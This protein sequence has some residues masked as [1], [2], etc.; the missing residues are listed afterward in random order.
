MAKTLRKVLRTPGWKPTAAK[1]PG[2]VPWQAV[3]PPPGTY[4]PTIDA[5]RDAASRGLFDL[6]Q[7]TER[8]NT[9]AGGDLGLATEGVNQSRG[10]SLADNMRTRT[11]SQEDHGTATENLGRQ[12][13]N[14]GR[15]QAQQA[16][17]AGAVG[18]GALAQALLKR[19]ANQGREQKGLDTTL[20][21]TLEGLSTS[22]QRINKSADDRIGGLTLDYN[23][24]VEDRN[25]VQLPRAIREDT[26]F[27]IASEKQRAFQASSNGLFDAPVRAANEFKSPGGTS[28]RVLKGKKG[29][30]FQLPDG[31]I[32]NARPA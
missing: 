4:D 23:R 6:R 25:Q 30:R 9:R 31:R 12:Y 3:S 10:W 20:A 28:Y 5:N 2:F 15:S 27:G 19:T 1:I 29:N 18:G 24:G 11:R 13:T 17:Q 16:Q 8:A 32:V 26:Q 21:R 22:D 7:D 14:L